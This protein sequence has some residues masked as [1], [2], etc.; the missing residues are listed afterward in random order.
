MLPGRLRMLRFTVGQAYLW[1]E[2]GAATLIDTGLR[3]HGGRIGALIEGLGCRLTR[4]II[5]HGHEDH[6]GSAAEL[7]S[8]TSAP[9]LAHAGD[10]AIIQGERR[11]KDPVLTEFERPIWERVPPVPMHPP[12]V[13]DEQV[14]DGQVLDFAGGAQILAVPGHTDGSIAVHLP[15][16]RVLFTGDTVASIEGRPIA[17]VFN[18]D[19]PA[20]LDSIRRLSE[21]DAKLACFGH[22]EP[23]RG[24]VPAVLA[25]VASS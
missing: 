15:E 5:T 3:D 10:V 2:S 14:R 23:F 9:V 4:M 20:L 8:A 16:H 11:R 7:K 24:D 12:V 21:L 1:T 25:Q 18:V 13:V 6:A 19:R 17:G 22:G